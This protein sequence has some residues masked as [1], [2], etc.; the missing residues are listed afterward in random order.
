M[1][2]SKTKL[3]LLLL[4]T[5]YGPPS[6]VHAGD[7]PDQYDLRKVLGNLTP[8]KNQRN[9]G[10]SW[11]FVTTAAMETAILLKEKIPVSLSEQYL[12]DCDG[13]SMGCEGG[14]VAFDQGISPGFVLESDYPY[15][16]RQGACQK[17]SPIFRQAQSWG[18]VESDPVSG[19]PSTDAIK[20]AILTYGSVVSSVNADGDF[21]AYTRGIFNGGKRVLY[22]NHVINLIGWND[23]EG[24]WIARN[25]WG[26]RWGENGY[27]RIKYGANNVGDTVTYVNYSPN[28]GK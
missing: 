15:N 19:F 5:I 7:L 22:P 8:V 18:Y 10:S 1:Q 6:F 12:I 9:C 25:S 21:K 4:L 27:L 13:R 24:Y 16:A 14:S 20:Q 26:I 17:N 2:K 23:E 28:R 11:A 3:F